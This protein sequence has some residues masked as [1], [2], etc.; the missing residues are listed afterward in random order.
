MDVD[1]G[2]ADALAILLALHAPRIELLG[3]T[4]V[5]GNT[6][7]EQAAWSSWCVTV[8]QFGFRLTLIATGPLI[9][10]ARAVALDPVAMRQVG[11]LLVKPAAQAKDPQ[12]VS[13]ACASGL[14]GT[15]CIGSPRAVKNPGWGGRGVGR[16]DGSAGLPRSSWPK[17]CS[18]RSLGQRP[19][20]AENSGPFWLK[21]I[22][23]ST[24]SNRTFRVEYG[25]RPND[26]CARFVPG[27]LPQ[28]TVMDGLRPSNR[29]A[30]F[31]RGTRPSSFPVGYSFPPPNK[32]RC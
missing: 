22:F 8:R 3:I 16:I 21:A 1:T 9:N 5:S 2:V 18:H 13:F 31:A 17:A 15:A 23:T 6:H 4:T 19:R 29:C 11:R 32:D 10:V 20:K 26:R 25:L 7:A 14:D 28:A 12:L 30:D 27:A 24:D